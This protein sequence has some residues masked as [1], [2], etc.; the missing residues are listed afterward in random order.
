MWGKEKNICWLRQVG[1]SK[2]LAKKKR[3]GNATASAKAAGY[4][5]SAEKPQPYDS[6]YF[7]ILTKQGDKAPGGAMESGN[8]VFAA[9]QCE[10]TKARTRVSLFGFGPHREHHDHSYYAAT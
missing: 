5:N 10:S 9:T 6:H 1:F 4:T 3:T 7:R 2:F 8:L